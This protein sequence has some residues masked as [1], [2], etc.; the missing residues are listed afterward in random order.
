MFIL[1]IFLKKHKSENKGTDWRL[2]SRNYSRETT[3]PRY[4]G[5]VFA[6]RLR[7]AV[8]ATRLRRVVFATRLQSNLGR[9]IAELR[10]KISRPSLSR[11][12]RRT[13]PP[14]A[15]YATRR[16]KFSDFQLFF[17]TRSSSALIQRLPNRPDLSRRRRVPEVPRFICI[18]AAQR[19]FGLA[20]SGCVFR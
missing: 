5:V 8:L 12:S 16:D 18:A 13:A 7:G 4:C 14:S 1:K 19:T 17:H 6:T 10:V 3:P 11:C 15:S 9:C 2:I 20:E